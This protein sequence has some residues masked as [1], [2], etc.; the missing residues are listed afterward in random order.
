[1]ASSA[2]LLR[3]TLQELSLTDC[4][5][6]LHH[7]QQL[8]GCTTGWHVA[9][10]LAGMACTAGSRAL[11]LLV[12]SSTGLRIS[13]HLPPVASIA[14]RI[15]SSQLTMPSKVV[16]LLLGLMLWGGTASE[17]AAAPA[18]EAAAGIHAP[19]AETAIPARG[20]AQVGDPAAGHWQGDPRRGICLL[21]PASAAHVC[22]LTRALPGGMPW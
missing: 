9:A 16:L 19:A 11:V 22:V 12:P 15:T 13:A 2:R 4:R 17:G 5:H 14:Q 8:R 6:G 1:L 10:P 18:T 21:L 20:F 7:W 3:P